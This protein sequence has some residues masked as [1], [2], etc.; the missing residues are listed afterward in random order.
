ME[1]CQ[2]QGTQSKR[3]ETNAEHDMKDFSILVKGLDLYELM[4]LIKR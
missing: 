2:S 1:S 3:K 4:W